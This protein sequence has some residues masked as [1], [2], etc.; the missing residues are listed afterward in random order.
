MPADAASPWVLRHLELMPADGRV[1]DVA[2][3]GGRHTAVVLASGRSALAVD[4]DLSRLPPAL[5]AGAGKRLE[6]IAADLETGGPPPWQGRRFAGVIVTNYLW[7]PLLP[8]IVAAV[9]DEGVLIF[10]TFAV[11][12]ASIGRP[13]NPAF[14]LKPG[15]LLAA[16]RGRLVPLAFEDTQLPDPPRRV[17]RMVAVG[18]AHARAAEAVW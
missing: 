5:V 4:R 1:L 3:G 2:C 6:T 8:D 12:Q 16:V 13:S 14:L 18:P 7:R 9:S 17:Q 11:G 10:E 15:E